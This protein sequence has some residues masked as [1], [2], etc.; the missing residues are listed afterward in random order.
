MKSIHPQSTRLAVSFT[1]TRPR[2]YSRLE[3]QTFA[4]A[5]APTG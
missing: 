1:R 3:K 4:C 5:D 2:G